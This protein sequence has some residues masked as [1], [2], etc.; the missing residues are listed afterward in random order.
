MA[1]RRA[2]GS[3]KVQKDRPGF[4]AVFHWDG[5]R[6]KRAISNRKV[7]ARKLSAAHALLEGG[8]PIR[9][10]LAEC[11]GDRSGSRMTFREAAPPASLGFPP[12]RDILHWNSYAPRAARSI[13]RV[14]FAANQSQIRHIRPGSWQTW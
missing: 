12:R 5:R 1:K 4:Y 11:F 13:A 3:I 2:F 8:T 6:Y 14:D 7:A 10:V 9:E